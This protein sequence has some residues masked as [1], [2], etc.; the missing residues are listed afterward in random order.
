MAIKKLPTAKSKKFYLVKKRFERNFC[1]R[2]LWI[3]LPTKKK[4][5][6]ILS[7]KEPISFIQ[8]H[9]NVGNL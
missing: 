7:N 1:F 6:L 5:K 3:F 4:R 9:Q 8:H 2:I